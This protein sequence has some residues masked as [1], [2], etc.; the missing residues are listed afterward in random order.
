M[1]I[2]ERIELHEQWL[3]SMESAHAQFVEDLDRSQRRQEAFEAS[4]NQYLTMINQY[5]TTITMNVAGITESQARANS[6][7]DEFQAKAWQAIERLSQEVAS[8]REL[9]ERYIRFRGDGG[10]AN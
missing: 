6:R 7:N 4:M 1:S 2:E 10:S 9:V 3:Q 8:L 5:L